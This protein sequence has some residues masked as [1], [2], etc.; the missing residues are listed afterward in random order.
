MK[1]LLFT[2]LLVMALAVST[3]AGILLAD[4]P[5]PARQ[6][7]PSDPPDA[8][9]IRPSSGGDETSIL[10]TNLLLSLITVG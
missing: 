5:P 9:C 4:A 1:K 10:I 7:L 8:D 3:P 2:L 6:C